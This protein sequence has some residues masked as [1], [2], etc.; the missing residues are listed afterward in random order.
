M[1]LVICFLFHFW[2]G[3]T[4]LIGGLV[5]VGI[6]VLTEAR[7]R[8]PTKAFARFAAARSALVVEGRRNAE[9]LQAMGMRRQAA[10]RWQEVNQKYLAAQERSSDV[11]S[12][13]GG[14]SRS[15]APCCNPSFSRWAPALSSIRS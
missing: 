14:A 9:V 1:Y 6:T 8:D 15:F 7:T 11:V 12:G 2:I 10:Q 5:L 3:M 4:A 13:L